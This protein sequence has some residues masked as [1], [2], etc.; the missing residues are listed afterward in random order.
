[1][2]YQAAPGV[3]EFKYANPASHH[4][5]FYSHWLWVIPEDQLS[6]AFLMPLPRLCAFTHETDKRIMGNFISRSA[7]GI[8]CEGKL[9]AE[10]FISIFVIHILAE[11]PLFKVNLIYLL[12]GTSTQESQRTGKMCAVLNTILWGVVFAFLPLSRIII[13][14]LCV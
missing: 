9:R 6:P 14:Y 10:R 8:I 3:N 7:E 5:E 2:Q 13:A 11:I 4:P 1:M 12:C